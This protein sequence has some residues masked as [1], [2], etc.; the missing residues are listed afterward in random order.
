MFRK[1]L[2]T[3]LEKHRA[4]KSGVA[5]EVLLFLQTWLKQ[6][7]QQTDKQYSAFLNQRGIR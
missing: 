6:H 5:V 1:K 7:V 4:A 3:Y 2:M